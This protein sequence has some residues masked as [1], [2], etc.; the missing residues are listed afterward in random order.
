MLFN[1]ETDEGRILGG[2]DQLP[3]SIA[4][5]ISSKIM[6]RRP[7][8]RITQGKKNV[9]IWFEEQGKLQSIKASRIVISMPFKVLKETVIEPEFSVEKMKCIRELSYGHVMK[10][11]MQFSKRFW[12]EPGSIGQRIFTD[13]PLRRIYHH[14]ID[15]P[16][17]RGIVL[18]FTSGEDAQQLGN[19]PL[20][21]RMKVAQGFCQTCLGRSI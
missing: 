11:A 3:K 9:E 21:G 7:V 2:N 20:E 10:I 14:S 16:G 15:Q 1:E 19:L 5:V 8:R 4:K 6:Y 18:S 12:D 13:T 17:P